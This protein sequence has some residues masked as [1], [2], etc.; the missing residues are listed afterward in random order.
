MVTG[1]HAVV[2]GHPAIVCAIDQRIEISATLIDARRVEIQTTIAEPISISLDEI[3][4]DGP[5]RFVLAVTARYAKRLQ[6]GISLTIKSQIDSTLGLGS[7]A[8]VTAA[9]LAVLE[10]FIQQG[11]PKDTLELH[12]E[13]H[14]TGLAVIRELQGRG[15]GADLAASLHG[16][17]LAYQLPIS[18]HDGTNEKESATIQSLPTA[19]TPSLRY[20]GFKTPTAQ[21]LAL[22]SAARDKD[23]QHYDSLYQQMGSSAQAAIDAALNSNWVLFAEHLQDYQ[24]LMKAIGVSN[25]ILDQIIAD[26]L[27][28]SNPL[29]VKIS[30]SG[31]GDCVLAIGS[32]P[33][34]FTPMTIATDG[35]RYNV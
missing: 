1:E 28:E 26:A 14:K 3:E 35:I 4:I 11:V 29:A 5:Y 24:H 19:P 13:L 9:T 31:L 6:H 18:R 21:V 10:Y 15:S 34:G 12:A 8:A 16:G 30:G 17:M 2:Y 23:K 22:V 7:S 25:D 32:I 33:E 27:S 20:S